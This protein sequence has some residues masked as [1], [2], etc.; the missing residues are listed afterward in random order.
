[1]LSIEEMDAKLRASLSEHRYVH[2]LGV[3]ETAI[4]LAGIYAADAE[5]CRLAGL[6]HDCAKHLSTEEMLRVIAE[7][8]IR[9]YPDEDK[10]PYLL[11]AP[12]G[13]AIAQRD[14]GVEDLEV[15]SAIRYHTVGSHHM[16][17]IDAIIFVAD[18]IEPNRKSFEG[19]DA[20]RDLAKRDIFAATDEC[21]RLTAEY[22][23]ANGQK[24]FTI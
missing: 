18:F 14:Y 15:L 2:S 1:M 16:S 3:T 23:R 21:R 6:L 12:A 4:S 17:L 9:L 20:V 24:V 8:G 5:K 11:H 19:L 7:Y 13:A 10:Y 22:C